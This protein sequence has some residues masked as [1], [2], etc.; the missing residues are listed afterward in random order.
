MAKA[1]W[2]SVTPASG[3]GNGNVSVSTAVAHTG[4]VVRSTTVTFKASGVS[5]QVATVNQAGKA[6]FVLIQTSASA[7][8]AGG[9]VTITGTT[10]STKLTFALGTGSLVI[11]LPNSYLANSV[12]TNNGVAIVGDPGAAQEFSFS[13]AITVPANVGIVSLTKQITVTAN[14]GQSANCTLTQAAG[15][16]SLS[17]SPATIDLT[18]EG[19][20]Q[21]ITV[22]SNTSWTVE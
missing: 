10:N 7:S 11:T 2:L 14:G 8:K 15:D 13:I 1:S 9:V 17:I 5:D 22:T 6:E 20:A 4:R 12:N 16:A 21:S 19:T 18:W 3:S